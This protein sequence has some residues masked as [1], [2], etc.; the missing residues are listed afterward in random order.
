MDLDT[1]GLYESMDKS[2]IQF[3][4]VHGILQTSACLHGSFPAHHEDV[5]LLLGW[6]D[7][8]CLA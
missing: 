8:W 6:W 3:T 4:T 2:S 5:L 1:V 7:A